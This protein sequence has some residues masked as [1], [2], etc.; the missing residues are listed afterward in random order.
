MISLSVLRFRLLLFF[1]LQ[2]Y[3]ISVHY[4]V[5]APLLK[6]GEQPVIDWTVSHRYS[7]FEALRSKLTELSTNV[8]AL[9]GKSWFGSLSND[10]VN[11]RKTGLTTWLAECV[12]RPWILE[13]PEWVEFLAV[14]RNV[15]PAR[16]LEWTP[17][18]IKQ[19]KNTPVA[20]TSAT[21]GVNDLVYIPS[22]LHT[23][24]R[25]PVPRS[26]TL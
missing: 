25:T 1:V 15:P 5:P 7:D 19:V 4:T 9:P 17:L 20:G 14:A 2:L 16:R 13:R 3:V 21:Y 12:S 26:R 6:A 11:T 8:P 23:H 18:E 22:V 10:L 24:A